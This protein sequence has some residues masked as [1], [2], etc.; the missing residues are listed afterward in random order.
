MHK[1]IEFFFYIFD[2]NSSKITK[3]Q[4]KKNIFSMKTLV[5]NTNKCS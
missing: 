3:K 4:L 5:E 1:K 2:V